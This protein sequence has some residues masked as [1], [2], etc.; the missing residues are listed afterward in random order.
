MRTIIFVT[1]MS[2]LAAACTDIEQPVTAKTA[3]S[4][5]ESPNSEQQGKS[6]SI[7]TEAYYQAVPDSTS[8]PARVI[9]LSLTPNGKAEMITYYLDKSPAIVDTG[10]WTT[11]SNGNL[12]LKLQRLGKK[13]SATLEFETD[14]DKLVYAGSE[15]G[16]AGLTL[17]VKP[18][19][20]AK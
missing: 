11:L 16:A 9:G 7:S 17:W 14:G 13:E 18:V 2:L 12:L 15:Y 5:P 4:Q 20:D 1:L 3:P 8:S 10:E 6:F 19:P